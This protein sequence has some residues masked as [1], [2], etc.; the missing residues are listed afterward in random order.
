MK[1]ILKILAWVWTAPRSATWGDLR[2][3]W[4]QLR[5]IKELK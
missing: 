4:R 5:R 3:Q 1:R 2:K